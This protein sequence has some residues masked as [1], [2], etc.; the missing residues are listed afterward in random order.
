M[1]NSSLSSNMAFV[2]DRAVASDADLRRHK[3]MVSD[4]AVM[5]N[6]VSTPH[7]RIMSYLGEGLYRVV[8][9]DNAVLSYVVGHDMAV[10]V[11]E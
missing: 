3:A 1:D 7:D 11:K 5:T 8:F 6:M 4:A 2:S 10:R 9:E